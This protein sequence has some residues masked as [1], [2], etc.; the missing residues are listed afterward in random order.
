MAVV[1]GRVLQNQ[2]LE[3]ATD[4]A[5]PV[6]RRCG[7]SG[8]WGEWNHLVYVPPPL[9]PDTTLEISGLLWRDLENHLVAPLQIDTSLDISGL[10]WR[11]LE[12]HL[13]AP[14]QPDT[15]LDISG[16]PWRE[17]ESHLVAP[18]Q[19]DTSLD[20]SGLP[21]RDLKSH[22]VVPPQPDTREKILT[23]SQFVVERQRK[24]CHVVP[25]QLTPVKTS[26]RHRCYRETEKAMS[27]GTTPTDTSLEISG[28]S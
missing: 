28:L 20:I 14:P 2:F 24:P 12:S 25:P 1:G 16:L 4:P 7:R 19:P 22:L 6:K 18:S 11:D 26:Q 3:F 5:T 17:L 23:L 8:D 10:P 27:R 9:S 13:V 21:W 15:S